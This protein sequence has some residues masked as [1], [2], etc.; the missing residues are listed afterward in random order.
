MENNG[1][2]LLGYTQS[3]PS[4][5][6][7]AVGVVR[8]FAR[9]AYCSSMPGMPL[10]LQTFTRDWADKTLADLGVHYHFSADLQQLEK[11]PTVFVGNHIGYLDIPLLHA[12]TG[13]SFLA[14]RQVSRWPLIGRCANLLN[15]VWVDRDSKNSRSA[16]RR[17]IGVA[18]LQGR[19]VVVFPSGT[20]TMDECKPWRRGIF[21]IASALGVQVCPFRLTYFPLRECAFID[22]DALLPHLIK[23]SSLPRKQALVEFGRA[24]L[25]AN[26]GEAADRMLSWVR[27]EER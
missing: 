9:M 13:A 21:E 8:T 22:Q 7:G 19:S 14:K 5:W 1:A 15:T 16:A 17:A 20:T 10:D 2:A 11:R 27:R 24:E 23:L 12:V 18:L 6:N 25:I 26:P 4:L 3:Q